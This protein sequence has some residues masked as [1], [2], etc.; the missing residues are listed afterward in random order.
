[1]DMTPGRALEGEKGQLGKELGTTWRRR[2]GPDKGPGLEQTWH[3]GG[4]EGRSVSPGMRE[5]GAQASTC[6]R[7]L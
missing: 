5:R 1:M 4:M 3:V 6:P 7:G 2:H